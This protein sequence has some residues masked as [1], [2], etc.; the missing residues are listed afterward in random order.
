[1]KVRA[2]VIISG[3][4]QNVNFRYCIKLKAQEN[5]VSGWAR[6]LIDGRVEAV[7]EGEKENVEKM[8]DFCKVGPP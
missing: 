3:I 1:M 2:H 7:F 4:V 8:I 6:N 5:N